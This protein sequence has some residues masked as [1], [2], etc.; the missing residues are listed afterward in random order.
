[1]KKINKKMRK[2]AMRTIISEMFRK[3]RVVVIEKIDIKEVKTKNI[4]KILDD[5]K[6]KSVLIII[7]DLDQK[8]VLSARNIKDVG[9]ATV[10]YID[11]V[12]LLDFENIL[13]TKESLENFGEKFGET[14]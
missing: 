14:S 2:L 4:K 11:P 8:I 12:S 5:L 7:K 10:D 13:F 6:L 3:K 9:I 1:E